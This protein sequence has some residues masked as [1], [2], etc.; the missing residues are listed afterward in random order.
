MRVLVISAVLVACA[1]S[2]VY[3]QAESKQK[4]ALAL[5]KCVRAECDTCRKPKER[6]AIAWVLKK[7]AALTGRS[8][9]RQIVA[10]CAVFDRANDRANNIWNSTFENPKHGKA[11]WWLEA[12]EWAYAFIDNP[13]ADPLPEAMHWG[14]NMDIPRAVRAGWIRIAGPPDYVNTFWGFKKRRSKKKSKKVEKSSC[15]EAKNALCLKYGEQREK[16]RDEDGKKVRED[17]RRRSRK[18]VR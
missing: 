8:F 12:R 15:L 1:Y 6:D 9:Y 17:Q 7:Q 14:G 13:P 18:N 10:Y 2:T 3:A 16:G 11:S 4:T 5:A